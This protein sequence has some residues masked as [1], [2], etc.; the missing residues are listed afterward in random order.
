MLSIL[1]RNFVDLPI[2]FSLSY[3]WSSGFI[4]SMLIFVQTATGV[5]LS[6]VYVAT[7]AEAFGWVLG[8]SIDSFFFWGVRYWHVWGVRAIFIVLFVHMGRALYY[9]RYSKAGV[10][11]VGFILYLVLMVEAFLGYILP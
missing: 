9:S 10:W 3:Y 4:L 6:F 7:T 11:K 5:V 1:R 8:S 2:N